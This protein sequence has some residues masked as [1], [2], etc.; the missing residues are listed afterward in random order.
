MAT[1]LVTGAAG[2]AGRHLIAELERATDWDIIG[3]GRASASIGERTRVLACDLRNADLVHRDIERYRPD[4]I[5]HLA[6]QSYVPKAIASPADTIINNVVG[7][8]NL[9]EAVRASDLEPTI[10]VAGS[11][12]QYGLVRPE[13]LPITEDQ[14][15]RPNNPYAV[16]KI[17]QDMLA[18]QYGSTYGMHIVRMRPFNHVGPGQSERFVVSGFARQIAEAEAGRIE[19]V[20]LVGNLSAKRDF[21]DVRDVVRAYRVA[22]EHGVPGEVYNLSSGEAVEIQS[23]LDMLVE[24]AHRDVAIQQDPARLRP[25]DTP[26]LVGDSSRFRQQTGWQP[27]VPFHHTLR[28]TLEYWRRL[29]GGSGM[30]ASTLR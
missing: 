27:H 10:V 13:E 8:L 9:F 1:A 16:S 19:P 26:V 14:P 28:D 2:F 12:E 17:T 21:L 25:S 30:N 3:F 18:F 24:L 15:F 11:A 6:A 22:A 23:V 20:I 29:V 4:Y 5:F 7:Q